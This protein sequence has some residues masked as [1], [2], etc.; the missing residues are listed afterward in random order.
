M[1]RYVDGY[2]KGKKTL[3]MSKLVIKH[4]LV[5]LLVCACGGEE[6]TQMIMD[7]TNV[8]GFGVLLPNDEQDSYVW[9]NGDVVY[10][11]KTNDTRFLGENYKFTFERIDEK[12]KVAWFNLS[13][14]AKPTAGK[15]IVIHTRSTVVLPD[16]LTATDI[17]CNPPNGCISNVLKQTLDGMLFKG[18]LCLPDGVQAVD[19]AVSLACES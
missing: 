8:T 2:K 14:T 19:E 7:T 10:L 16:R 11:C 12:N 9:R 18:E 6:Q 4:L 15:Y 1:G 13:G 17:V 3:L 5:L